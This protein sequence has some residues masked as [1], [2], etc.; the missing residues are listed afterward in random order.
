MTSEAFS[1]NY[2]KGEKKPIE[3]RGSGSKHNL[4][5]KKNKKTFVYHF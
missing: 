4:Q 1:M 5:L 2:S 3:A